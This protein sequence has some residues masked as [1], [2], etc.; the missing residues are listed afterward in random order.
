MCIYIY[1]LYSLKLVQEL[2]A[3]VLK[4]VQELF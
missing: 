4:L 1:M 3:F 2:G